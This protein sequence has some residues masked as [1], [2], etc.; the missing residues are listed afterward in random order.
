MDLIV[1][2]SR[3][4]SLASRP[5]ALPLFAGVRRSGGPDSGR[6]FA[7]AAQLPPHGLF[8]R[9]NDPFGARSLAR[10]SI[11]RLGAR[12]THKPQRGP[13]SSRS[14]PPKKK[15]MAE[16]R[17]KSRSRPRPFDVRPA[18]VLSGNKG[19]TR[20]STSRSEP[21]LQFSSPRTR[22]AF[23]KV[24]SPRVLPNSYV[25]AS[26]EVSQERGSGGPSKCVPRPTTRLKTPATF[27]FC[28]CQKTS[29]QGSFPGAPVWNGECPWGG[30]E[31]IRAD[32]VRDP[33]ASA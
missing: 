10:N 32:L 2:T 13:V 27:L 33:L 12:N 11:H 9:S 31:T 22:T 1:R 28:P 30:P 20:R 26:E 3:Q 25:S 4:H 18:V 19:G 17:G 29:P 21:A 6:G 23:A 8:H 15:D 24:F 7:R 14:G 5:L 16:D